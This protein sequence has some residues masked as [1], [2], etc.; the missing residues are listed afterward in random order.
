M[1][2]DRTSLSVGGSAFDTDGFRNNADDKTKLADIYGQVAATP[3]LN[4]QAEYRYRDTDQGDITLNFDPDDF[5][6]AKRRDINQK[7][8]RLGARLS[9]SPQSD[10]IGS[11][12][13]TDR[14][15]ELKL[16]PDPTLGV[17]ATDDAN[18]YQLEGQY[19]FRRDRFNLTTGFGA[20]DI[21]IDASQAL[22]FSPFECPVLAGCDVDF[23][24]DATQQTGYVYGNL[25]FPQPVTWTL[26]F[27]YDHFQ[28]GGLDVK[29]VNPKAGV[30]WNITDDVR[31]RAAGFRTVKRALVVDQTIEPTQIAGFNQFFDDFNGSEAWRYGIGLDARLMPALYGGI[32]VSRRDVNAP[33]ITAGSSQV[34]VGDWDEDFIGTYFYW[35]PHPEWALTAE[36]RYDWFRSEGRNVDRPRRV[37]TQTVPVAIRYFNSLG[38]FAEFGVSFVYQDVKRQPQSDLNDGNDSFFL[39]DAAMGY[40]LPKRRGI[41]SL[42]A[43]N[44]LDE[45]F[46]YQGDNFRTNEERFPRFI[47]DRTILARLTVTF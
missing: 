34:L 26:G 32:E 35:T 43:R 37:T 28:Q 16:R 38:I 9:P 15:E 42:E 17:D 4:L 13:Y 39:L 6:E 27:S 36:Y 11:F 22:D 30:Q 46:R 8:A 41:I 33:S 24:N 40:R 18:G 44:L 1:L 23:T 14:E 2:Y 47:P 21:D 12:I 10:L 7:T 20:Y 3:K 25:D 5:D 29:K 31:L 19:L 45:S